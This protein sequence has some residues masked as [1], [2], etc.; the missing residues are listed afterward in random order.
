MIQCKYHLSLRE[1]SKLKN[2]FKKYATCTKPV[3]FR[4]QLSDK[5][6]GLG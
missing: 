3:A 1:T 4:F 6:T 2:N 5:V